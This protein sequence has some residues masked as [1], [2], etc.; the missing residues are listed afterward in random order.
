MTLSENQPQISHNMSNKHF[1]NR[2]LISN[3]GRNN[4]PEKKKSKLDYVANLQLLREN[5]M[6][7]N[8]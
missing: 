6:L 1:H 5:I 7:H 3:F 8:F 2:L 4:I